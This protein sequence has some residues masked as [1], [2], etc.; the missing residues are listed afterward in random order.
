MLGD[1]SAGDWMPGIGFLPWREPSLAL[2]VKRVSERQLAGKSLLH[3]GF[4]CECSV[5]VLRVFR[6]ICPLDERLV[7]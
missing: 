1:H 4:V 2:C 5:C 7:L 6:G 3:E